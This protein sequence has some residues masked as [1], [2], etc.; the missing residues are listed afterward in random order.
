MI[1]KEPVPPV[2]EKRVQQNIRVC[3]GKQWP[4]LAT[5]LGFS[6]GEGEDGEIEYPDGDRKV[7]VFMDRDSI[8]QKDRV[9]ENVD[10]TL[11][12]SFGI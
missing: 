4:A 6:W 9:L 7:Y 5:H 12:S 1:N 10:Q 3:D 11:Q 2:H 8:V